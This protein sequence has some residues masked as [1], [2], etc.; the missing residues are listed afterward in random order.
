M[1]GKR[2]SPSA[3]LGGSRSAHLL[4]LCDPDRCSSS[5]RLRHHGGK[6]TALTPLL[7][8]S[9][10]VEVWSVQ[11]TSTVKSRRMQSPL[12]NICDLLCRYRTHMCSKSSVTV[13]LYICSTLQRGLIHTFRFSSKF[14]DDSQK[15]TGQLR[16]RSQNISWNLEKLYS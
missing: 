11:N 5:V 14:G 6:E 8:P 7:S 1:D 9:A 15:L 3:L 13:R 12:Y 10:V 4:S 2:Q 16:I